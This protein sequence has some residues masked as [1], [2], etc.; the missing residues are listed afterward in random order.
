MT[1]LA[2]LTAIQARELIARG[3]LTPVTLVEACLA[4]IQAR[5]GDIEAWAFL[6]PDLARRQAER[7]DQHRRSGKPLGPLHGI[8][9]GVKDII[10]TADMPTENGTPIDAGRRPRT[11]ANVVSRLRAA[12]AIVLGKS[13]TTELAYFTPGKT[14][15]P[16]D[17]GRTPGGSSQGSAAAVAAGMVPLAVGT[18]TAGSVIRPASFCGIVGFKPTFGLIGRSGMLVQSPPLDTVGVFARTVEDAAL[19]AD[20]LAGYDTGD[21][22]SLLAA[23]PQVFDLARSEPPVKPMIALVRQ[24]AWPEAEPTTREAFAEL[25]SALGDRCTV[26]DVPGTFEEAAEAHRTVM[27]VGFARHLR[28][29]YEHA[30]DQ[31]SPAILEAIEEGREAKA[32][33]YLRALELREALYRSMESILHHYDSIVTPAAPGEAPTGLES[34][35]SPAF[36]LVW[37][38]LGM[39]AVTLPLMT[40]PNG[41]PLGV[42]LVGRR[43][44]DGRLLRTASWLVKYLA[45]EAASDVVEAAS[46]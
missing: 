32:T 30:R 31:L 19:I 16:H 4:R 35:G 7:A 1:D 22:D 13:V 24:P 17:P 40:G 29:Y 34:T 12:G 36:N 8:P 3:E 2:D 14:R 38:F 23:P 37:T 45:S 6:D 27:R 44:Y 41:M 5:D 10:D 33:D 15:N 25:V 21:S 20:A 28:R 43:G 18:Q 46:S 39:P 11:D 42:Q 26:V 9:V